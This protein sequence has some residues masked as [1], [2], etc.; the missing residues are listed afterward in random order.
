MTGVAYYNDIDPYCAKV[1]RRRI[2]DGM[3]PEGYVD[4]RDIRD[5]DE[6]ELRN[7]S[8]WHLFAGIGGFPLGLS[9]SGIGDDTRILTAGFPCQPFSAAG[10]R[11]GTADERYLWPVT[12]WCIGVVR[13]DIVLLENVSGLISMDGGRIF[14]DILADLDALGYVGAWHCVPA[15]HVGA[16][17]RRDRVWIVGTKVMENARRERG[18]RG[19]VECGRQEKAGTRDRTTRPGANTVNV[20]D[21]E[22][23]RRRKGGNQAGQ[24]GYR[25][26]ATGCGGD[27]ADTD[28]GQRPLRGPNNRMGRQWEPATCGEWWRS[29]PADEPESGVGRVAHGVSHR[30]DRLKGLGN[31][32]VPQM[33]QIIGNAIS[34]YDLRANCGDERE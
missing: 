13:P 26:V 27:V 10:K 9:W 33:A 14:G 25:P 2:D 30:V 8:Q 5:V 6:T 34:A 7:Y 24:V 17:H 32:I 28:G 31:A 16:P 22:S 21:T 23:E 11:R 3:L 18:N 12:A 29:D 1:L 20:A 15:S 4:D 19:G